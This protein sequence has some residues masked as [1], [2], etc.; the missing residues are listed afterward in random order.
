[1]SELK[2]IDRLRRGIGSA[3]G[4]KAQVEAYADLTD[5]AADALA[6]LEAERDALL[7]RVAR[8]EGALRGAE[9]VAMYSVVSSQYHGCYDALRVIEYGLPEYSIG[10]H[11]G[12]MDP[13]YT[14]VLALE[15]DPLAD[16]L[17]TGLDAVT[18]EVRK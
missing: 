17:A 11:D 16:E 14:V 6:A 10:Y 7:K 2:L 18:G 3:A 12:G 1:M 5:E 9:R 8:L 13:S 15:Q 4:R